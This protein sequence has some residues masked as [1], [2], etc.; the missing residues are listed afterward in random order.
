MSDTVRFAVLLVD[1][2]HKHLQYGIDT[3]E[4]EQKEY[5]TADE[6]RRGIFDFKNNLARNYNLL[7]YQNTYE[8]DLG[9]Q[10]ITFLRSDIFRLYCRKGQVQREE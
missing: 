7:V 9:V 10:K 4:P 2:V 6:L 3:G 5:R 1:S 8:P